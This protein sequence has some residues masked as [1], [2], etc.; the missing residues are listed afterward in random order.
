MLAVGRTG[1]RA[2][3]HN[4]RRQVM[5]KC[6]TYVGLDVHKDSIDVSIADCGRSGESRHYGTIPSDLR[7]V[8]ALIGCE[9][10]RCTLGESRRQRNL[11]FM[12]CSAQPAATNCRGGMPVRH[13]RRRRQLP[14]SL[15]QAVQDSIPNSAVESALSSPA[16]R[17]AQHVRVP[18]PVSHRLQTSSP[19][20]LERDGQPPPQSWSSMLLEAF[21]LAAQT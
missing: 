14:P 17:V 6:S 5:K 3:S 12:N 4:A 7:S 9:G 15:R 13:S 2:Q 11:E 8:D 21:V 16:A 10:T 1:S 19:S 20:R 18:D